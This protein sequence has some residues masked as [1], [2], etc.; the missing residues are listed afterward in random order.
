MG[1]KL[2]LRDRES[3]G[4]AHLLV[5][6]RG[7]HKGKGSFY[8]FLGRGAIAPHPKEGIVLYEDLRLRRERDRLEV[9]IESSLRLAN[10]AKTDVAGVPIGKRGWTVEV[11]SLSLLADVYGLSVVDLLWGL[12]GGSLSCECPVLLTAHGTLVAGALS[13]LENAIK[14]EHVVAFVQSGQLEHFY[15]RRQGTGLRSE[16]LRACSAYGAFCRRTS[17]CEDIP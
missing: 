7:V 16:C 10:L 3:E 13:P 12:Q 8:L 6:L 9:L 5:I 2:V 15:P 11:R 17:I 14:A 1:R 4:L